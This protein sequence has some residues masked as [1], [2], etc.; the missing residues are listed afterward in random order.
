M[1]WCN[2]QILKFVV[3]LKIAVTSNTFLCQK[4]SSGIEKVEK[5]KFSCTFLQIG[6]L[7]II[8][9]QR[10]LL[11]DGVLQRGIPG[12][13]DKVFC[14]GEF[15][16]ECTLTILIQSEDA[17]PTPCRC[18]FIFPSKKHRGSVWGTDNI[19]VNT[20]LQHTVKSLKMSRTLS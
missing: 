20:L 1:L 10:C 6:L 4:K 2:G 16:A 18:F 14:L 15:F 5:L 8:R 13:L 11:S 19:S 17:S 3:Q 12:P 7:V 9:M